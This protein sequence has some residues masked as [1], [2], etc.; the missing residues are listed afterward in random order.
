VSCVARLPAIMRRFKRLQVMLAKDESAAI[1][2]RRFARRMPS[3]AC[4]IRELLK[5][6]LAAERVSASPI[7]G[8]DQRISASDQGELHAARAN[9]PVRLRSLGQRT[10]S[11]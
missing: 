11:H 10:A 5:R 3:R 1:D 4:A 6:G 9:P 8:Q 2:D 7:K